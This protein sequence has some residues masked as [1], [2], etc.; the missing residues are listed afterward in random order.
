MCG[1]SIILYIVSW[2]LQ[3]QTNLTAV[4]QVYIAIMQ[5]QRLVNAYIQ[6][7]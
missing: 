5:D 2:P 7:S 3:S 1:R 4:L 6:D